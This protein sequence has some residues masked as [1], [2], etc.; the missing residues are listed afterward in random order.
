MPCWA[1]SRHKCRPERKKWLNHFH[2]DWITSRGA[3][4]DSHVRITMIWWRTQYNMNSIYLEQYLWWLSIDTFPTVCARP[5]CRS[6]YLHRPVTPWIEP[7]RRRPST[8]S[9]TAQLSSI[10]FCLSGLPPVDFLVLNCKSRFNA[11]CLLC[12]QWKK[13]R[14]AGDSATR[15]RPFMMYM[16]RWKVNPATEATCYSLRIFP[17]TSLNLVGDLSVNVL[18]ELVYTF[19]SISGF[20]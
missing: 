18:K 8:C 13:M 16:K 7:R 14:V 15:S 2:I 20:S 4:G 19:R 12:S 17:I 6:Q 3:I 5:D 11:H 9:C 1:D 10:R